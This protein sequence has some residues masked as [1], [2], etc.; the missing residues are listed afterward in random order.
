MTIAS[1]FRRILLALALL[2]LLVACGGGEVSGVGSGGSGLASG[3]V[4]GFGSIYV[5]GVEIEDAQASTVAENADGSTTPVAAK[6][7][8]RVNVLQASTGVASQVTIEPTVVGTVSQL[9]ATNTSLMV[10][11]QL[12]SVNTGVAKGPL[13]VF[14]GGYLALSDVAVGD[15]VEIHGSRN[16]A[17]SSGAV[18]A[19][20]IEKLARLDAVRV[21]GPASQVNV[22]AAIFY[23]GSLQVGH[24]SLSVVPNVALVANG[25]E[26]TV[27]GTPVAGASTPAITASRI[28]LASAVRSDSAPGSEAQYSGFVSGYDAKNGSFSVQGVL[29]RLQGVQVL[30]STAAL[31]DGI[32][33]RVRGFLA[34]DGSL[35]AQSVSVQQ[36]SGTDTFGQVRLSGSIGA[37]LNTA[38]F[39]VRN[40]PVDAS[41][42]NTSTACPGTAL[43]S[44]TFVEV[45]ATQQAGTDVVK[46]VS[47]VC[48]AAS[49]LPAFAMRQYQ[50]TASAVVTADKTL[51][52]LQAGR[53]NQPVRW[54]SQTAFNGLSATTLNGA[55]VVIEAYLDVSGQ[56]IAREIR[57]PGQQEA[58]RFDPRNGPGAWDQYDG[59]YREPPPDSP[60]PGDKPGTTPPTDPSAPT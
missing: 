6:L 32:Y 16:L 41:A 13:T 1:F 52:L 19:S 47:L 57:S 46:A 5:D 36:A 20:R 31:A 17:G 15:A 50:G 56:L 33:V 4:S 40:V 12:V 45:S 28:R 7:G 39:V 22:A 60:K 11:G 14:G 43:A 3:T 58:D 59:Q 44:G 23:I 35:T 18:M 51:T 49:A 34:S 2:H 26:V 38:S 24:A 55:S 25:A 37:F 8:Q 29:V 54:S 9:D 30:P 21:T 42:I 53:P 48:P 27:W 10:A